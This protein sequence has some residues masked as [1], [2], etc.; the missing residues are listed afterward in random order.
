[1]EQR[2]AALFTSVENAL[3][4]S[5]Y[6]YSDTDYLVRKTLVEFLSEQNS[7]V[8]SARQIPDPSDV[9]NSVLNNIISRKF[10][11]EDPY[12][13]YREATAR[14]VE[15]ADLAFR[16]EQSKE[17][18]I[19]AALLPDGHPRAARVFEVSPEKQRTELAAWMA[20]D[21]RLDDQSS[22]Q[23]YK[24]YSM[25]EDVPE[26]EAEFEYLKTEALVSSGQIPEDLLPLVAGFN[27]SRAARSAISKAL[28]A[29]RR[30]D[31]LGQFANEFGRLKLIFGFKGLGGKRGFFSSSPRIVGPGKGN[32]SYQVQ[33]DGTENPKIPKGIYEVDA[34][35]GENVKAYLPKSAV[36]GLKGKKE[37]VDEADKKYAIDLDQFLSSKT[38][39]P[40]GWTSSGNGFKSED[41]KFTA[42]PIK[43]SEAQNYLDRAKERGDDAMISGTGAGDAF[44]PENPDAFL[45]ADSKGRTKGIAQDWAGIQEI[46]I[47]NGGEFG[48]GGLGVPPTG[49]DDKGVPAPTDVSDKPKP[50]SITPEKKPLGTPPRF[51]GDKGVPEPTDVSGLPK[52]PS[53]PKSE[54]DSGQ[55]KPSSMTLEEL[56]KEM[57]TPVDPDKPGSLDRYQEVTREFYDRGGYSALRSEQAKAAIRAEKKQKEEADRASKEGLSDDILGEGY[58][59]DKDSPTEWSV[60]DPEG[61]V[62]RLSKFTDKDGKERWELTRDYGDYDGSG[63]NLKTESLGVFDDRLEAFE[64]TADRAGKYHEWDQDWVDELLSDQADPDLNQ[65]VPEIDNRTKVDTSK[66]SPEMREKYAETFDKFDEAIFNNDRKRLAQML[67]KASLD[68]D[69]PDDVYSALYEADDWRANRNSMVE[70]AIE[71]G[72]RGDVDDM[73]NDP[74][75]SGW[76]DRLQDAM[77]EFGSEPDDSDR[78]PNY[79]LDQDAPIL[80]EKQMEPATGKQYALLKELADERQMD[81]ATEQ[82][83]ADALENKN[84][85]KAQAGALINSM[86]NAEFKE[87]VDPNKPSQRMLDSLQGYLATK[88]L[89]PSEIKST[90]DS[91]EADPSRANVDALLN[92]LRRKKDKPVDLNQGV[93][94][95]IKYGDDNY[96]WEDVYNSVSVQNGKNGWEVDYTN[97]DLDDRGGQVWQNRRFNSEEE[98]LAFAEELIKQNQDDSGFGRAA[99][100]MKGIGSTDADLDQDARGTL[101]DPATDKQWDFLESL[102]NG[103]KIDDPQLEAAV[104]SALNDRNLTKGE[105]GAFIG[106]LRP[107][108]DRPD[109]RRE[110]TAKQ[111]ASIRRAALERDLSPEEKKEL[112]DKLDAGPSFDEASELLNDLKSRP[113]TDKGMN[114]LLDNML[115]N[116]DLD[117]LKYLLSKPEYAEFE[118]AIRDTIQTL[119]RDQGTDKDFDPDLDIDLNQ[120][121]GVDYLDDV[122][123]ATKWSNWDG[124]PEYESDDGRLSISLQADPPEGNKLSVAFDG[125]EQDLDGETESK[126]SDILERIN[127]ENG[128]GSG[129]SEE[130][131][132]KAADDIANLLRVG[133]GPLTLEEPAPDTD[134]ASLIDLQEGDVTYR[135]ADGRVEVSVSLDRESD[136]DDATGTL[137]VELDGVE[138]DS[139]R[140]SQDQKSDFA[141][142]VRSSIE[143]ALAENLDD[144][145][146]DQNAGR[147]ISRDDIVDSLADELDKGYEN[148]D[149]FVNGDELQTYVDEFDSTTNPDTA[150]EMAAA[151]YDMSNSVTEPELKKRLRDLSARLDEELAN[152][153]GIG[154]AARYGDGRDRG[155][156]L[157]DVAD[158]IRDEEAAFF[159]TDSEKIAEFLDN[160]GFYGDA[161]SNGAEA[162]VTENED[163]TFTAEVGY[164]RGGEE[165]TFN[166]RDEAIAWAADKVSEYNF[167]VKPS[168]YV[169]ADDLDLDKE[170][171]DAK[172]PEQAAAFADRLDGIADDIENNR[173]DERVADSLREYGDR[174]RDLIAKRQRD[175]ES[176]VP[177]EPTTPETMDEMAAD[178]ELNPEGYA[179]SVVDELTA[180]INDR[181]NSSGGGGFGPTFDTP[182][183]GEY[184]SSDGR[185]KAYV[186]YDGETDSDGPVDL[187][188]LTIE[189]DGEE[190]YSGRLFDVDDMLDNIAVSVKDHFSKKSANPE[191][192]PEGYAESIADELRAEIIER[193]DVS[194]GGPFG[195]SLETPGDGDYVSKDGRVKISVNYDGDVDDDRPVDLSSIYIEVD[196]EEAY[197]GRLGDVDDMLDN[198]VVSVKDHFSKKA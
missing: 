41:G 102:L 188:S 49:P 32:N 46:S 106:Q 6:T 184:V 69:M 132:R 103:K 156:D 96:Q 196:G 136:D 87:G 152:R 172:T 10:D 187:S 11:A 147:S 115:G 27:M 168:S 194:G 15:F 91:V 12:S 79:D 193:A 130:E 7:L 13:W 75:F 141:D 43:S 48:K 175:N 195:P 191:L 29:I 180:E 160:N 161:R 97:P 92:K 135:G 56:E 47:A 138:I 186:N 124:F 100:D 105:V 39:A 185:V 4:L 104:R 61:G 24:L 83:F 89:T 33:F 123:D 65:S 149:Y 72:S 53:L 59:L 101:E 93:G 70:N 14:V 117:G 57:S 118:D 109:A 182:G 78:F 116:Q 28:A 128:T 8:A 54:S 126:I 170:A 94:S 22:A 142:M 20:A 67:E 183:D 23:I 114:D 189:V 153:F 176:Q 151:V 159:E 55:K 139:F 36:K 62:L 198:I 154:Q 162:R 155:I 169:G 119:R 25:S 133:L 127:F 197:S 84:L 120:S 137:T 82:A 88:D 50:P 18:A 158:K 157:D 177:D 108:Q 179:Q 140:V 60:E 113:I 165:Q 122:D 98:A 163:G 190:V 95:L 167:D 3:D 19:F 40:T 63:Q 111:I 34:S 1:M 74:E 68:L 31:R 107:L 37:V 145:D 2:L 81:P 76:H 99:E 110:P 30:R 178:P 125:R 173:G 129:L 77:D 112:Q 45:V 35:V 150:G 80:S 9:V 16:N 51:P 66:I 52:P 148:G 181:A 121:A 143:N 64:F 90:L 17:V 171:S 42:K 26:I 21:S 144:V 58:N 5:T 164:D 86:R 38:D 192:N 131:K 85:N 166:D 134:F 71:R 73:L 146:L 174:I 44:D